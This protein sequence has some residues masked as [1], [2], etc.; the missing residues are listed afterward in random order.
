MISYRCRFLIDKLYD[1]IITA[2]SVLFKT[3]NQILLSHGR[4]GFLSC[5]LQFI[6]WSTQVLILATHSFHVKKW[7]SKC[8][9]LFYYMQKSYILR[10]YYQAKPYFLELVVR[11]HVMV[12][13]AHVMVVRARVMSSGSLMCFMFSVFLSYAPWKFSQQELVISPGS[14]FSWFIQIKNHSNYRYKTFLKARKTTVGWNLQF[15]SKSAN[16]NLLS[17]SYASKNSSNRC[18]QLN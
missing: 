10:H 16:S 3:E 18:S 15:C 7:R 6:D 13:R 8:K 4:V 11:P 9:H 17:S 12:L 2:I 14:F 1:L 5:F